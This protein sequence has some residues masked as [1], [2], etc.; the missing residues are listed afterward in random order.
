M[1]Q[2]SNARFPIVMVG[3]KIVTDKRFVQSE[4]APSPMLVKEVGMSI[5]VKLEQLKNFEYQY[6]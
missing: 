2:P 4:N 6:C 1:L 3:D 5:D